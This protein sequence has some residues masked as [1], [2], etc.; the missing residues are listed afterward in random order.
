[1]ACKE[2]SQPCQFS[3]DADIHVL[4]R[5]RW[6]YCQLQE[7]KSLDSY[8]P[9]YVKQVL[10]TLPPTLDD[11]YTRMLTRIKK[12]YHQEALTL[13]RWL[14]YARSPPTLGELVDAAITDPGEESFIDTTERGGLRDALNI[15]S[16]LVM[17]EESK[18][19]GAK[20][21]SET[22]PLFS[23]VSTPSPGQGGTMFLSQHLTTDTRVRLAHF[24]VKEYLE[25][26]RI[27][28]SKAD[29]FHLESAVGHHAL[30]QSCLTY[31]RH[32]SKSEEKTSTEQDLKAFP[33]LQ[34]AAESWS[35]HSALQR[36]V[37]N[38]REAS[39][40]QLENARTD[41][42]LIYNPDYVLNRPFE[43]REKIGSGTA[44]YYAALLR[45]PVVVSSLLGNGADVNAQGGRYGSALQAA[46]FGGN[47]ETVKLLLDKGA[48]ISAQ[49][50]EYGSALQAASARGRTKTVKLLLDKGADIS[51]QGGEYGSAL[52][53]ASA[54]GRTKTVKLLLD[55]GADISAQGGEYGSALQAASFRGNT[56][57]VKLLLDR[58][59]DMNA[60]AGP[61]GSALQ[62][63]SFRG[64]TEIVRLLLD[65]GADI[66]A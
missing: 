65:K 25:S 63:A 20:M 2:R 54:R 30:A 19:D 1:M 5:F 35:Y 24:S 57:T 61:F 47:A 27:L 3:C 45:L 33:M 6:A 59:A 38:G 53:A 50:G 64:N 10:K 37:E 36:G 21:R 32:Y 12:M 9:K 29:Q 16:G 55:K 34:Y 66:S 15:L 52:Q 40:L 31:L 17:I 13:L 39:L 60:Q 4:Y 49:G 46:S 62:A 18:G 48:D 41:W 22:G 26:A 14:A 11:T 44:V 28:E 58:G 42:L 8:K 43:G 23:T 56:E 51:A 7:L